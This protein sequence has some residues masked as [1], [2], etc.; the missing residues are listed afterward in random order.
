MRIEFNKITLDNPRLS[1]LVCF[2]KT[3]RGRF[4]SAPYIRKYFD[5][6]VD[7]NDYRR[8]KEKEELLKW[9]IKQ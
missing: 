5:K 7:K 6:L 1:S 3:I 9:I 4:Y 2:I 8:G